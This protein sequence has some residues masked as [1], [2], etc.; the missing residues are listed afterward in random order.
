MKIPALIEGMVRT[1][2]GHC[3][4]SDRSEL[5]SPSVRNRQH[6]LNRSVGSM[7]TIEKFDDGAVWT[8][9]GPGV[10]MAGWDGD[11]NDDTGYIA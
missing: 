10:S 3:E 7:S 1:M 8:F 4:V 9:D 6:S 11:D 2:F 5:S